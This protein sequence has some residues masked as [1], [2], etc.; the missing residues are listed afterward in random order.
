MTS[1]RKAGPRQGG[2]RADDAPGSGAEALA[3]LRDA[4][5]ELMEAAL[6][7]NRRHEAE[8]SPLTA[9]QLSGMCAAAF[10]APALPDGAGFLLAFDEGADY[11][12]RN[13][14]WFRARYSRFVYI[15]RVI[16]DPAARGQ[17]VARRLYAA[18]YA[19][20]RASGRDLVACE[21]NVAPPNAPSLAFHAREGFAAVAEG[22]LLPGKRVA[23]M[24]RRLSPK[25]A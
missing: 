1:D 16:V 9:A 4:G 11:E 25:D 23:Y 6:R 15:D 21:V 3:D 22:D 2:A 12:S 8:T 10:A 18:L 14:L 5:P 24:L 19:A 7:L 13:F 20:A 17:G